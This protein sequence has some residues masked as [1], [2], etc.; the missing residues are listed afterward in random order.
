MVSKNDGFEE[1]KMKGSVVKWLINQNIQR[2]EDAFVDKGFLKVLLI[3]VLTVKVVKKN[4][5]FNDGLVK[6]IKGKVH[7][8]RY[9]SH[10]QMNIHFLCCVYHIFRSILHTCC[11]YFR[12]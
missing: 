10:Q 1:V 3:S 4:D 11:R 8:N 9:F 6:F 12:P 2:R 7:E 5:A